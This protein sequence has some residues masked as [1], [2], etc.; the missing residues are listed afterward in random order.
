MSDEEE[1]QQSNPK[2]VLGDLAMGDSIEILLEKGV[3]EATGTHDKYGDWELWGGS[4]KNATVH[5]GRGNEDTLVK[6][7]TGDIIFF[8]S[9]K[10]IPRLKN[11]TKGNDNVKVKI[12]KGE[13]TNAK[14]KYTVYGLEKLSEGK[15]SDSLITPIEQQLIDEVKDLQSQGYNIGEN[16]FVKAS[17]EPQYENKISEERS[18]ELYK[19]IKN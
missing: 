10:L 16:I 8:P 6:E 2:L 11:A 4:V 5:K 7:Y 15:T 9:E 18:K 1:E 12:T 17:Q 13:K 3:A 14:G 19:S